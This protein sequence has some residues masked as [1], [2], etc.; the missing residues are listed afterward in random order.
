METR[1]TIEVNV[2]N[3]GIVRVYGDG[4]MIFEIRGEYVKVITNVDP[5]PGLRSGEAVRDNK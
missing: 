3:N 5:Q 4:G 2:H 1:K